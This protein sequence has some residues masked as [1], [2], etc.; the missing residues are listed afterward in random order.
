[1]QE[2][3]ERKERLI[4]NLRT[5]ANE[6]YSKFNVASKQ[7][8]VIDAVKEK[9]ITPNPAHEWVRKNQVQLNR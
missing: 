4:K 6:K 8:N 1:M 7:I 5:E 9:P 3:T 2:R